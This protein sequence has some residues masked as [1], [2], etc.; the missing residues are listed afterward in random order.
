MD[1][2]NWDKAEEDHDQ[3]LQDI[4]GYALNWPNNL[5][6]E[7]QLK[8]W[9][10]SIKEAIEENKNQ[11]RKGYEL[12]WG[13]SYHSEI[14]RSLQD[15]L[16]DISPWFTKRRVRKIRNKVKWWDPV[17]FRQF[18][19]LICDRGKSRQYNEV[20][21]SIKSISDYFDSIVPWSQEKEDHWVR[22]STPK[23]RDIILSYD[24]K[25]IKALIV[26]T[27]W[28]AFH[29]YYEG[30]EEDKGAIKQVHELEYFYSMLLVSQLN[31]PMLA[32]KQASAL[33]AG[34]YLA[35]HLEGWWD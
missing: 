13:W 17:Y 32:S 3:Y 7:D 27:I 18:M 28:V 22:E 23:Y 33:E 12:S 6:V 10:V 20:K 35:E 26:Y 34:R 5:T 9:K 29:K 14:E 4:S 15:A 24:D 2:I 30:V 1:K 19:Y 31:N 25:Q 21:K 11:G 8:D 16:Q